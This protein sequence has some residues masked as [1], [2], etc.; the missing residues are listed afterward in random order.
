MVGAL[1][2]IG[3]KWAPALAMT[4]YTS[5]ASATQ[6]V[7]VPK[8]MME[9]AFSGQCCV[10][11]RPTVGRRPTMPHSAEGTRTE[12]PPS[13][14]AQGCMIWLGGSSRGRHRH[15]LKLAMERRSLGSAAWRYAPPL[16][17]GPRC[18]RALRAQRAEP[19]PSMPAHAR[20]SFSVYRGWWRD[21]LSL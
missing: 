5:M 12:P 21:A 19:P 8:L 2:H 3:R 6:P 18:G 16:A 14:P 15:V 9:K 13:M 7:C 4:E 11:V 1:G 20:M 10:E 17:A